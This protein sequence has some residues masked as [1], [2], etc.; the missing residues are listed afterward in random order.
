MSEELSL[1]ADDFRLFGLSPGFG[2]DVVALDAQWRR[3]QAQAHPDRHVQGDAASAR[4]AMQWS[5]RINQAYRR[6]RDPLTRAAYL[7]ELRGAPV[8]PRS[9]R[10]LP[11]EFLVQ[12]MEWRESLGEASSTEAVQALQ[13]EVDRARDHGLALLASQLDH[14]TDVKGGA[15]EAVST[16]QRLMFLS[17]FQQDID[18][19]VDALHT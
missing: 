16:V 19:R 13:D 5:M 6:L 7:C 11:A 3:L 4:L 2:L 17:K 15:Q 10:P 12:Q 8:E 14:S 1:D 18:R 9:D